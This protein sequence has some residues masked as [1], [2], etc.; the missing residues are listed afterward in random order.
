MFNIFNKDVHSIIKKL[1][2]NLPTK[3]KDNIIMIDLLIKWTMSLLLRSITVP[4][5]VSECMPIHQFEVIQRAIN[6]IIC[7]EQKKDPLSQCGLLK[8]TP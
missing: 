7:I 1:R 3:G 6:L 2:G 8:R 4:A 5:S